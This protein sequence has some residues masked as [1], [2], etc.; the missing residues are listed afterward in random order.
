MANSHTDATN[1]SHPSAKSLTQ[2]NT[3]SSVFGPNFMQEPHGAHIE[4]DPPESTTAELGVSTSGSVLPGT[5]LSPHQTSGLALD[6]E[7]AAA[8]M[9]SPVSGPS[10]APPPVAACQPS[11]DPRRARARQAPNAPDMAD[12]G[13]ASA[14][15]PAGS[16][17]AGVPV[18][19]PVPAPAPQPAPSHP[20]TRGQ[21][22]I[23]WPKVYTDGTVRYNLLTIS[24]EPNSL[25]DALGDKIGKRQWIVNTRH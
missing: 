6:N 14:S 21:H 13:S 18:G 20:T 4:D 25:D 15:E 3:Q 19:A 16:T 5:T 17:V 22:G 23:R 11:A 24:G 1:V 2:N 10:T 9:P 8:T 7:S 12:G